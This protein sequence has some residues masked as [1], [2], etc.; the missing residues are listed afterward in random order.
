MIL[1]SRYYRSIE[2]VQIID[3]FTIQQNVAIPPVWFFAMP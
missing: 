3:L 1:W 2:Y